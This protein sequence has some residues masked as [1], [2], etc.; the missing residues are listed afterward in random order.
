VM[1]RQQRVARRQ[2]I[3]ERRI[4]SRARG[5]LETRARAPLDLDANRDELDAERA[6][7]CL[8]VRAPEG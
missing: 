5:R 2:E 7:R 4:A 3:R 6:R 1:C 8:A